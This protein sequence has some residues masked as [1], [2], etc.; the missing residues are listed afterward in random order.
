MCRHSSSRGCS[1]PSQSL[2]A[3]PGEAFE[4]CLSFAQPASSRPRVNISRSPSQAGEVWS[5]CGRGQRPGE[6]QGR[7]PGW[8]GVPAADRHRASPARLGSARLGSPGREAAVLPGAGW[9]ARSSAPARLYGR[10]WRW[11]RALR[12]PTA[13]SQGGGQRESSGAA[14][15]GI[16]FKPRHHEMGRKLDLS[17]LTDEEAKHVWEV[18]QRDFDLRKKEE[19]RLE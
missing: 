5:G 16:A 11:G 3:F 14:S 10:P 19:E 4:G 2:P 8:R 9:P 12:P 18:V 7:P 15:N 6:R 13:A 1:A 17:K